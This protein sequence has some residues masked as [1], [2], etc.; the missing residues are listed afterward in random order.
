VVEASAFC[1]YE[2]AEREGRRQK[3]KEKEKNRARWQIIGT[4]IFVYIK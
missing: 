2:P 1:L 3:E 4:S